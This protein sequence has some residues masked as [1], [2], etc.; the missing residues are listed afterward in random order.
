MFICE[1]PS[2]IAKGMLIMV[3]MFH[4]YQDIITLGVSWTVGCEISALILEMSFYLNGD[5]QY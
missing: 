4:P 1:L 3:I 2:F 5:Y